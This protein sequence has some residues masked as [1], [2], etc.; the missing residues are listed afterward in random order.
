[1]IKN[2]LNIG[3][4]YEVVKPLLDS[5]PEYIIVLNKDFKILFASKEASMMLLGQENLGKVHGVDFVKFIDL[6]YKN[7]L[8]KNLEEALKGT[9][10]SGILVHMSSSLGKSFYAE[11]SI[12]PVNE[13][14]IVEKIICVIKDV[15]DKRKSE[16]ISKRL[17]SELKDKISQIEEQNKTL[18]DTKLAILNILEDETELRKDLE[19]QEKVI[20]EKVVQRTKELQSEKSKLSASI[21]A[22]LKA[23]IMV[24]L[25]KN[26]IQTNKNIESVLG[27]F[28]DDVSFDAINKKLKD[29]FNFIESYKDCINSKERK[30][31]DNIAFGAKILEVLF[32]PL[33]EMRV[34]IGK[35]I[36]PLLWCGNLI[37]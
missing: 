9:K 5:V 19:M 14:G 13:N 30:N 24:D 12:G 31:Y 29:S 33:S 36:L 25:N 3:N 34:R 7:I 37:L 20:E 4:I 27:K 28:D 1:M 11:I 26:I 15:T 32:E 21:D 35:L 22:L 18:E 10:H 16:S 23:F 6:E 8:K 17:Y 2:I